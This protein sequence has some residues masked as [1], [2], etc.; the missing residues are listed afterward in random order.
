LVKIEFD[1]YWAIRGGQDPLAWIQKFG[2]RCDLIHQKDLPSGVTPLN[3]LE[4]L[5]QN[6]E[7]PLME[8]LQMIKDDH[9]TEIGT[10]TLNIAEIIVAGKEHGEVKYVIVEQD[11][12]TK[13]ELESV[14][15]S[16]QNLS[17]LLEA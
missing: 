11:K 12:T 13:G 9:F 14:A 2:K 5:A 1:T 3:L 6:P 7:K 17:R 8:V 4:V 10:G 15:I 16:Y